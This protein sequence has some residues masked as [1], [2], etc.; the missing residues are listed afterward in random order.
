MNKKL[1]IIGASG[2]GKVAA[3]I[4]KL[5]N[6]WENIFFIDDNKSITS[7]MGIDIIDDL[8]NIQNYINDH[9]IFIAIG[10][11]YIREK[12]FLRIEALGA[13]IPTLIHPSSI[14][15]SNVKIGKGT[16]IVAGAIINC[17]SHIKPGCIINTGSTVGHDC[18]IG[19]FTHIAPGVNIGGN[20]SVGADNWIGIGSVIINNISITNH[21]TIGAGSVVIDNI[22]NPGTYVGIPAK[23]LI[24]NRA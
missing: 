12:I 11:C 13:N 3:D 8:S 17:C 19:N 18:R 10:D 15:G 23:K 22:I 5:M 9:D 20:T 6:K 24:K 16:I 7:S 21:C 4:A 1:I 14:I 2:H